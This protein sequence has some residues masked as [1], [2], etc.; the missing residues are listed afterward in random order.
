MNNGITNCTS[1]KEHT[2]QSNFQNWC[3][4]TLHMILANKSRYR[5]SLAD[6]GYK[7]TL[8]AIVD[9]YASMYYC[10]RGNVSLRNRDKEHLN[11]W[12]D[13]LNNATRSR[14]FSPLLMSVRAAEYCLDPNLSVDKFGGQDGLLHL[15]HITPK[16]Y[17]YNK[18]QGMVRPSRE[19]VAACFTHCKLVLLTKK[20][21]DQCLDGKGAKFSDDDVAMLRKVFHVNEACLAESTN[22]VG[23]S[24]KSNGSGLL[25]MVHL[26]NSGV[27]FCDSRRNIV[28]PSAWLSYLDNVNYEI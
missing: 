17:V 11:L 25:R 16:G 5:G 21:S 14:F 7:Y 19:E 6:Q 24:P 22:L 9:H 26:Y 8:K 1:N 18:L 10:G 2:R 13:H 27:R 12:W 3:I 28:E 20:E 4:D 23:E 15:E